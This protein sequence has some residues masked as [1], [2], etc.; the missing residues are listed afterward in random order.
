VAPTITQQP[1][2]PSRTLF[3]G[4]SVS[5]TAAASGTPPLTYQWRKDGQNL[6]GKTSTTLSLTGVTAAD[7]GAYDIVVTSAYGSTSSTPVAL[8]VTPADAVAPTLQYAAGV[9]SFDKVRIWFSEPLDPT[10]A[11]LAANYKIE[12]L[13]VTGA[14]LKAPAGSIGDNIVELTTSKQD[15]G[16]TYKVTVTGVKDQMLPATEVAANSMITFCSWQLASGAL[17]FCRTTRLR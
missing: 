14:A 17:R 3:A 10:T 2:L 16:K 1:T 15:A 12:G 13:T 11:Q 8:V 4:Y 6:S 7:A 9:S 5:L